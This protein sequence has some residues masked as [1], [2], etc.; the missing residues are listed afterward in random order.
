[1]SA[2]QESDIDKLAALAR[3]SVAPSE[4][5]GL[6]KDIDAILGYVSELESVKLEGDARGKEDLRN[7]TRPDAVAHES[8]AHTAALLA[9][10]P[11]AEGEYF[12]VKKVL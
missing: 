1:M 3:L 5:A 4:R 10:A 12:V 6:A 7:I 11:R 9:S 8:G 2:L